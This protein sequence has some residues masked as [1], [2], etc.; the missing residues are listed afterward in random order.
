[1]GVLGALPFLL[2]H[3]VS[4]SHNIKDNVLTAS[5]W[6]FKSGTY[7]DH[8]EHFKYLWLSAIQRVRLR[9]L[10][11]TPCYTLNPPPCSLELALYFEVCHSVRLTVEPGISSNRAVAVVAALPR[12]I[13]FPLCSSGVLTFSLGCCIE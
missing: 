1:M 12:W 7:V 2:V 8:R 3:P 4:Q 6:T 9:T 11:L 5:M 13:L 10:S